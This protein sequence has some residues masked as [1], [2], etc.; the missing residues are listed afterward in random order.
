[1]GLLRDSRVHETLVWYSFAT[2]RHASST[3]PAA[4][5]AMLTNFIFALLS[6]RL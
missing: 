3:A 2:A 1:M 6:E 4:R 5:N